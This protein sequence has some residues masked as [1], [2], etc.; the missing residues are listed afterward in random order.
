M[1]EEAQINLPISLTASPLGDTLKLLQGA[2]IISDCESRI[3]PT[4]RAG[5]AGRREASRA[6]EQLVA[7]SREY[8]L[9]SSEM[10][11][12]AVVKRAGDVAG[13]IPKTEIV[14]VGFPEGMFLEAFPVASMM[15]AR[16]AGRR[17]GSY[18][19]DLDAAM[20]PTA[21]A[22]SI[23]AGDSSILR[24]LFGR[25]LK[26]QVK[27]EPVRPDSPVALSTDDVLVALAGMLEPDG[28]MPGKTPEVRIAN[29]LAALFCFVSQGSTSGNGPFRVHV[30][31][32]LKYLTPTLIKQLDAAV[33]Q[34]AGRAL[35]KIAAGKSPAGDWLRH[36]KMFAESK[37]LDLG[38]FLHDLREAARAA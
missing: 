32:L 17:T 30:A 13:E 26:P 16:A 8:G 33:A 25:P 7:L 1:S 24:R 12:V 22:S 18:D 23:P 5:V 11:L 36:A 3:L 38:V 19:I 29:S 10:S 14:P 2:R 6:N 4:A 21:A 20:P 35:E 31:K 34:D 15:M 37:P 9:A 27:S 28:G